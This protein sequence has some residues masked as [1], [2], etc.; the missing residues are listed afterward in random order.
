MNAVVELPSTQIMTV[1]AMTDRINA[2]QQVTRQKM[3]ENVHYGVIPG[4]QKPTLYKAG[5]EM[6]L[7]MFNIGPTI[8]VE[9]LTTAAGIK[10]RVIVTGI[11]TPSG[12]PIGEGVGECSSNEEKYRWRNAVCQAEFDATPEEMRRIKWGRGRGG[13]PYTSQQ[14][15]TNPDDLGNTVLKMAKKRAQID[16]T[17]TALGVSDL[18]SQD[19]EDL[20]PELRQTAGD[21]DPGAPEPR[22]GDEGKAD[23]LA[24]IRG[25][26]H[27]ASK[28][29]MAALTAWWAKLS[30][31]EQKDLSADFSGMRKVARSADSR[32]QA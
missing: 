7:T 23:P 13:V 31:R 11:H 1:A 4:T 12:Q 8:R 17:L 14:I 3:I 32:S 20:P 27:A 9:D 2:I 19:V 21:A 6:L 5:S 29:G 24:Q 25:D 22:P 28:Q 10:Y 26:G 30:A 16:M 15:R 18:F